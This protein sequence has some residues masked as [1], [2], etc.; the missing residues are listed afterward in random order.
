MKSQSKQLAELDFEGSIF[1]HLFV[2]V[3]LFNYI[4]MNR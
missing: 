4:I 2:H 3:I 1:W